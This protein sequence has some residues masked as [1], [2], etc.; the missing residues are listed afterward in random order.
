M[1]VEGEVVATRQRY[2][3][4]TRSAPRSIR[5][6]GVDYWMKRKFVLLSVPIRR[7]FPPIEV[8]D[9]EGVDAPGWLVAMEGRVI[10]GWNLGGDCRRVVG[11]S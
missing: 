6:M 9:V 3:T 7:R 4:R 10:Y 1:V 11:R 8:V 2:L 5:T